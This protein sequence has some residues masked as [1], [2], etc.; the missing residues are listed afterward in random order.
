MAKKVIGIILIVVSV[1]TIF[2]SGILLL[3]FGLLGGTF[4][5]VGSAGGLSVEDG[6]TVETVEG[7]V[8]YTDGSSTTIYY[9][10]DGVPYIGDLNV[11]NS[12]YTEGTPVTVEYDSSNPSSFAVPEMSAVFGV[13]GGVFGGVGIVFGIGGIIVGIVMLVIGIV[14]I[15]KAKKA[16]ASVTAV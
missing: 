11:Y 16:A 15:K 3:T 2:V 6:A 1:L 13:L 9:E 10:V 4:G 12:A 8:Y 5:I 14:L 7:E